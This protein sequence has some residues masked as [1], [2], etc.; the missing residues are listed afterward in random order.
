MCLTFILILTAIGSI[1]YGQNS[2][3][4]EDSISK[5]KKN[6]TSELKIKTL[7][8]E[9]DRKDIESD[10]LRYYYYGDN[11]E[12]VVTFNPETKRVSNFSYTNTANKKQQESSSKKDIVYESWRPFTNVVKAK[13]DRAKFIELVN[14]VINKE[15]HLG[16]SVYCN[17]KA[18]VLVDNEYMTT[19]G[20]FI[21]VTWKSYIGTFNTILGYQLR[22]VFS[23]RA[24]QYSKIEKNKYANGNRCM[25]LIDTLKQP[26]IFEYDLLDAEL[27][28][29]K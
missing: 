13:E 12:L 6:V 2:N 20:K 11:E 8:G 23:K 26:V 5:I 27:P 10:A 16:T 14:K 15:V 9:P 22:G 18:N 28:N 21:T 24:H 7:F 1:C 17:Y 3:L 25:E 4:N 19:I 29:V